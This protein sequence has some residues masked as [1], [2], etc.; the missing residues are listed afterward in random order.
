[1]G[2]D[3]KLFSVRQKIRKWKFFSGAFHLASLAAFVMG[4][5]W[6]LPHLMSGKHIGAQA[7]WERRQLLL[8]ALDKLARYQKYHFEIH[9][10]YTRDISR[11]SLP[12]DLSGGGFG[13]VQRDYEISVLEVWPSR[14]LI[15]ASGIVN[16]DRVTIDERNRMSAN[17]VLPPPSR[18]YLFSEADR[19]LRLKA[20]G[21][22]GSESYTSRFWKIT[23][24]DAYGWIAV[25]SR[26]PVLG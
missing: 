25:G 20:E 5:A 19:L 10:R 16:L 21:L 22:D 15:L 6:V 7:Q 2:V 18:A 8:E 26:E 1:M 23:K 11:L 12:E 13:Q 14:F 17:F 24:S 9:G 4:I 3:K